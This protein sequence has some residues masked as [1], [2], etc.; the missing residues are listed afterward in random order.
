M[1]NEFFS[2][3]I[4]NKKKRN[5]VCKKILQQTHQEGDT[6]EF[7]EYKRVIKGLIKECKSVHSVS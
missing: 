6:I 7:P 1:E 3:V 5:R 4:F 2:M